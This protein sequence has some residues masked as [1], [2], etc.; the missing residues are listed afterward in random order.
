M[1]QCNRS[2]FSVHMCVTNITVAVI[3]FPDYKKVSGAIRTKVTVP[4][5][6]QLLRVCIIGAIEC[7]Y[8]HNMQC[9]TLD[10]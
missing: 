7:D 9:T 8:K 1:K 4:S 2:T 3:V 10:Y 5:Y 6:N